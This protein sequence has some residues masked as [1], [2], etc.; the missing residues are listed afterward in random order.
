MSQVDLKN[1]MLFNKEKLNQMKGADL[2]PE[3]PVNIRP[4]MGDNRIRER[5]PILARKI[6]FD[7]KH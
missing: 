7:A 2:L 1:R 5:K 4:H 6:V 3:Y